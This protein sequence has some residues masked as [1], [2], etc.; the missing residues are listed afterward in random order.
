MKIRTTMRD[1]FRS[2]RM[3]IIINITRNSCW[4][5]CGEEGN[6]VHCWWG[7]TS[8]QPLRRKEW[9]FLKKLVIK[10]SYD[11]VI[12]VLVIHR[13]EK[14]KT[15]L[16]GKDACTPASTA[17]LF[18]MVKTW[19]QPVSIN[20]WKGKDVVYIHNGILATKGG[21]STIWSN[22]DGPRGSMWSEI[23]QTEEDKCSKIS[24]MCGI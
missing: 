17:A 15:Q 4:W 1:H 12:P 9:S 18:I 14:K 21:N 22:M 11:L 6:F 10:P 19:K 23:S 2:A 24:P 8:W 20:I 3:A 7:C 5:A 16:I 13:G